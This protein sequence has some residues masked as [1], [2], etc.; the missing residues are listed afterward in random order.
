MTLH[1]QS[2]HGSFD[3]TKVVM[4]VYRLAAAAAAAASNSFEDPSKGPV[5][6]MRIF[7]FLIASKRLK[8]FRPLS[9]KFYDE[10]GTASFNTD[11]YTKALS[12]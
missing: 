12:I 3:Q 4:S 7:L 6:C 9:A 10:S 8:S 5:I 2:Q 1:W 11:V